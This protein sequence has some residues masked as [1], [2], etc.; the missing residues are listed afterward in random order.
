[1][2][3]AY[4]IQVSTDC[5]F[6]QIVWDTGRVESDASV[7]IE[8]GGAAELASATRYYYH[9]RVWDRVERESGWSEAS[10]WEMSL[11]DSEEW[12]AK[13][14]SGSVTGD[15]LTDEPCDYLRNGFR[16]RGK[17]RSAAIYAT[18]HGL[19]R[20]YVNGQPADDTLFTPG[21]TSYHNRLQYQTYDVTELLREEENVLGVMLGNGWYK[22]YLGYK[23]GRNIYGDRRAALVQLHVKYA[24]GTE[25]V[26]GSDG[27]WTCN[28]GALLMSELYHGERYDARLE[29]VGL[30]RSRL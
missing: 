11:L 30:E 14:I 29:Q 2:Q 24:D 9:V 25:E 6:K 23:G 5:D 26:L 19:Y 10:Y 16:L 22:G 12:R 27:G 18:A 4:Q 21:W 8:Y 3:G 1:M 15:G 7:H 17:V 13:W 20:L 28:T